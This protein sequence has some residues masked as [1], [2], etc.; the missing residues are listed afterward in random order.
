MTTKNMAMRHESSEAHPD[1][2]RERHLLYPPD[3]H[4]ELTTTYE[5]AIR[6][7]LGFAKHPHVWTKPKVKGV[8]VYRD[9]DRQWH[10]EYSVTSELIP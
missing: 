2:A 8:P 9:V 5:E 4:Y 7:A 1:P 10:W 6:V 3:F